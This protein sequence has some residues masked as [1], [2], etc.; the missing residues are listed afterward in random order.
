MINRFLLINHYLT[1]RY[2]KKNR[3]KYSSFKHRK[4]HKLKTLKA[5]IRNLRC[6]NLKYRDDRYRDAKYCIET[7]KPRHKSSNDEL[8]N[9]I[10]EYK[11]N[12]KTGGSYIEL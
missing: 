1:S 10:S 12:N 7:R 6:R 4:I 9:L 5:Y 2:S 11:K 8:M 3:Y